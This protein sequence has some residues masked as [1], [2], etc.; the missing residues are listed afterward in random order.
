M[1]QSA[2]AAPEF[3]ER[4][5]VRRFR[6]IVELTA[7]M[8]NRND[9]LSYREACCLIEC[10]RKSIHG[11]SPAYAVE[12]DLSIRPELERMVRDRWP[13]ENADSADCE[14]LVN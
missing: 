13:F 4:R 10:A 3:E 12:F 2:I 8:I 5:R 1:T 7:G 14:S 6:M 11:L 9:E